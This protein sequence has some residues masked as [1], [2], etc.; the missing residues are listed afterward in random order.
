ME[1]TVILVILTLYIFIDSLWRITRII[2]ITREFWI[3]I[4]YCN[5][6]NEHDKLTMFRHQTILRYNIVIFLG[7]LAFVHYVMGVVI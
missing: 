4:D 7:L 3:D 2:M 6:I 5:T 1:M